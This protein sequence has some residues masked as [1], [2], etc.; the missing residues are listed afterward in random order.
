MV[1]MALQGQCA[2]CTV[3]GVCLSRLGGPNFFA[4][5]CKRIVLAMVDTAMQT[6]SQQVRSLCPLP[7]I[8]LEYIC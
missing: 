3:I 4:Q 8:A 7:D 5:G 1:Y 2:A 6:M